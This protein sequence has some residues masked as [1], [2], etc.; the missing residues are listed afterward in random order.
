MNQRVFSFCELAR[1]DLQVNVK[2]SGE[3]KKE[4]VEHAVIGR[5]SLLNPNEPHNNNLIVI[6]FSVV[7]SGQLVLFL[8]IF[9]T[10]IKDTRILK[11]R[12]YSLVAA[13]LGILPFFI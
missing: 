1:I 6:V 4:E 12:Y 13:L 8:N 2:M 5:F 3:S 11:T 7:V 9:T 10:H